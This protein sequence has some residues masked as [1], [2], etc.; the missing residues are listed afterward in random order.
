MLFISALD[1]GTECSLSRFAGSTNLGA[2][3]GAPESCADIQQHLDRLESC[4]E[5]NLVKFNKG[6]C[7]VCHWRGTTCCTSMGWGEGPGAPGGQQ[8]VHE[9]TVC[10]EDQESQWYLGCTRESFAS[11]SRE[12][13]LPF[14]SR[15]VRPH[16]EYLTSSSSGVLSTRNTWT[17]WTGFREEPKK[18]IRVMELL[19]YEARQRDMGLFSLEKAP[20]QP[21]CTFSVVR[22]GL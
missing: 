17:C 22:G 21:Y 16:L 20:E 7:R 10:P 8:G 11:R 3:A 15:L 1:G 6:K 14:C 18:V 19:F 2:G 5:R 9:S 12:V 4:V 13:M